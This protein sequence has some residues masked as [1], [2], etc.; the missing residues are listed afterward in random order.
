MRLKCGLGN[1]MFQYALGLRLANDRNVPFFYIDTDSCTEINRPFSLFN[2]CIIKANL[3]PPHVRSNVRIARRLQRTSRFAHFAKLLP[4]FI[5]A[6]MV[7]I[8]N[9]KQFCFDSDILKV[10]LPAYFDGYWQTEKYFIPVADL[11]R[12]HFQL[13]KPMTESRLLTAKLIGET[14]GCAISIHVRRG[15]Y[16]ASGEVEAFHGTCS[17]EY[18]E[19][20]MTK[21]AKIL[22][23]PYFF[24]FSDDPRWVRANLSKKWPILFVDP[25]NDKRDFEDMHLM[26]LCNHHII[27][28]SSFS[29][30]GAWLN[31]SP[32][33]RVIAP[34][35]WFANASHNT[36]DIVPNTWERM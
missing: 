7:K 11:V 30:W 14:E 32:Y 25:Q 17:P 29:W 15:D 8:I 36:Q 13:V 19:C 34:K 27:A 23:H 10:S 28:N 3:M 21:I 22:K 6:R 33:K 20:A 35:K 4:S 12:K 5:N 26:A 31:P 1:Q 2:L 16:V 18:Y 9:E 24:V